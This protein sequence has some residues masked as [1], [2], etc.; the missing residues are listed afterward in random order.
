MSREAKIAEVEYHLRQGLVLLAELTA[1]APPP[2]KKRCLKSEDDLLL[3][4]AMRDYNKSMYKKNTP[5]V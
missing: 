4:K 2:K 3:D 1:P 5:A